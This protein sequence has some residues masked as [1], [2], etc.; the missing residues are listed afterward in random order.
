MPLFHPI[1]WGRQGTEDFGRRLD[2]LALRDEEAFEVLFNRL[3]APLASILRR[4]M[5]QS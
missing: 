2:D 3:R 4:A 1:L 5:T